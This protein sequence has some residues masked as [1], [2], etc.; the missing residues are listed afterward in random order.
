MTNAAINAADYDGKYQPL[1][2]AVRRLNEPSSTS[3]PA[4]WQV[5]SQL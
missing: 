3:I 1:K 4:T 5:A 2:D